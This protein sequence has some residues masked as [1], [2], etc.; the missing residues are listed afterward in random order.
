MRK[1]KNNTNSKARN[2]FADNLL[3]PFVIITEKSRPLAT[4]TFSSPFIN[5]FLAILQFERQ[6]KSKHSD[7][8]FFRLSSS[9][10][11]SLILV[12]PMCYFII[13]FQRK[14]SFLNQCL[15]SFI[16]KSQRKRT[17]LNQCFCF[18]CYRG[19]IS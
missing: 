19:L 11:L 18:L 8:F 4:S 6:N 9:V 15:C 3:S 7:Y 1:S 12:L 13:K 16:I 2:A 5:H 10:K 17:F 14:R